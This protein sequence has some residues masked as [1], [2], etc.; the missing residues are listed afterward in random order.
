MQ[1]NSTTSSPQVEELVEFYVN[2]AKGYDNA[3]YQAERD[4]IADRQTFLMKAAKN[5][6]Q[7]DMFWEL[8]YANANEGMD[9]GSW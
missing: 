4:H 3:R 1:T 2:Y 8:V 5:I 7:E 9:A 6:G